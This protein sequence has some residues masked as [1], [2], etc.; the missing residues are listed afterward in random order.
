MRFCL[1]I[2]R[3]VGLIQ[4]LPH[5]RLRFRAPTRAHT[6][7]LNRSLAQGFQSWGSALGLLVR[8][9]VP[10][11]A[12]LISKLDGTILLPVYGADRDRLCRDN[13]GGV[14]I[15]TSAGYL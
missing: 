13:P 8:R 6:P 14:G 2:V 7:F 9:A 10:P 5:A 3:S 11:Q 1:I 12:G 15:A 4:L